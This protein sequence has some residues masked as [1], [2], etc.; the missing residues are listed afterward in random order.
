M[1]ALL[2]ETQM[3]LATY[4]GIWPLAGRDE[5]SSYEHEVEV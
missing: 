1:Y 5:M 4:L 3:G 2:D